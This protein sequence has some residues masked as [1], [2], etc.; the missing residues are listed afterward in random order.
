MN[1]CLT[2]INWRPRS[3]HRFSETFFFLRFCYSFVCCCYSWWFIFILV[4][5]SGSIRLVNA[6]LSVEFCLVI[7]FFFL[8]FHFQIITN[9]LWKNWLYIITNLIIKNVTTMVCTNCIFSINIFT[10]NSV[11]CG[12]CAIDVLSL[13]IKVQISIVPFLFCYPE[14][15]CTSDVATHCIIWF[16]MQ[17]ML[18]KFFIFVKLINALNFEMPF[19]LW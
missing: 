15:S 16:Y 13:K 14:K 4:I 3:S 12:Q 11:E 8:S 2:A 9:S 7:F 6:M 1:K 5:S 10:V 17:Q 19:W 18:L